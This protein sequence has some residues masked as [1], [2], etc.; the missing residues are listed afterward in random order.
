[1]AAVRTKA[2]IFKRYI[3]L[4]IG[5]LINAFGVILLTKSSLGTSPI[6]SIPYVLSEA[7]P[8]SMGTLNFLL[9]FLFF[10]IQ[11][12][13]LRKKMTPN[14]FIQIPLSI[15]YSAFL[16]IC[17]SLA[18]ALEPTT[19]PAMLGTLLLGCVFRSVGISM[20][21][22][23]DV[24]MLSGEAFVLV[25]AKAM[26]KEYSIVKLVS[27]ALMTVIAVVLS[28]GLLGKA[29]GVREGTLLVVLLVAPVSNLLTKGL[30]P[31]GN[32]FFKAQQEPVAGK[33]FSG[34][35]K[36]PLIITISSQSGS[37]GHKVGSIVAK[38]LGMELYDNN[39][40]EM[41]AKEGGFSPS[42]VRDRMIG[43]YTNRF[44]EFFVENYAYTSYQMESYE[45]IYEAQERV[46]EKLA[47]KGNCVIVG[48]CSEYLLRERENVF[49]VHI[50]ANEEA[51]MKFLEEEYKV[52][53]KQAREIMV[54][55]D[56]ERAKYFNH[57][58][59]ED[60]SETGRFSLSLDS[61]L[62][63]IEGTA[64]IV[65]NVVGKII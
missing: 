55:H 14:D 18:V 26:K 35:S 37:G 34:K 53:S 47:Q 57:F 9:Y 32:H 65:C 50:H 13:I 44:W 10:L 22:V 52:T 28:F 51:K 43:L 2:E 56:R 24:A 62:F 48:Y 12:L 63:G 23:A 64:D 40:I 1:M 60:W 45:A 30:L 21:V 11:A 29:V 38:R 8:V 5:L 61:S 41:I 58:T 19:Y 25:L 16:D 49:S 7:F 20:Q 17:I 4:I 54:S 33:A 3:F 36:A 31:I 59:G 42:Y 6:A 46:I 39:L 15:C 27:D